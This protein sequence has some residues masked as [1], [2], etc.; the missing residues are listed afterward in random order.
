[1]TVKVYADKYRLSTISISSGVG[2][3]R[4]SGQPGQPYREIGLEHKLSAEKSCMAL[5]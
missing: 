5:L 4:K 3:M 2:T 1:M